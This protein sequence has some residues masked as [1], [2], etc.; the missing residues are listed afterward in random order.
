MNE[1][2]ER[3]PNQWNGR[4]RRKHDPHRR[5]AG[6]SSQLGSVI[7]NGYVQK[8]NIIL[9]TKLQVCEQRRESFLSDP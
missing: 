4:E 1:V 8:F 7:E 9:Q 3:G 5:H 6:S 2:M